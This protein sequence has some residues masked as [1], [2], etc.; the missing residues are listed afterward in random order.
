MKKPSIRIPHP[1]PFWF[2][3]ICLGIGACAFLVLAVL[4]ALCGDFLNVFL[5]LGA[6]A[7]F[8]AG[9]RFEVRMSGSASTRR[10]STSS[11]TGGR[12]T[13]CAGMN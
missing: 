6:A 10:P 2:V 4:R 13:A 11:S 1:A 12:R 3:V 8:V 9:V 5:C 7:L